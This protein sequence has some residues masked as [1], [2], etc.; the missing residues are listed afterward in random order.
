[1][2]R[3]WHRSRKPPQKGALLILPALIIGGATGYV[4]S[5]P[6]LTHSIFDTIKGQRPSCDIKGN[7]SDRGKRSITFQAMRI[8]QRQSWTK[9]AESA[10]CAQHGTHGQ[11][12][13]VAPA[14]SI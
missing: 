4:A 11:L 7:I 12:V 1:M 3:K 13:G 5:E 10:G 8:T 6:Q 2:N 14:Y 9:A